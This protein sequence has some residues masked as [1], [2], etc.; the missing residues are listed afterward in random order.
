[1]IESQFNTDQQLYR[2]I[3]SDIMYALLRG[4]FICQGSTRRNRLANE[5]HRLSS[6]PNC[7][8]N[9]AT[10]QR[11]VIDVC[12]VFTQMSQYPATASG[13]ASP[14]GLCTNNA[15]IQFSTDELKT[16]ASSSSDN[17]RNKGITEGTTRGCPG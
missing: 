6:K 17:L 5:S 7:T 16:A 12:R 9:Y 8:H 1:M 4:S 13:T 11:K 2:Q 3:K 15:C 14:T 10:W